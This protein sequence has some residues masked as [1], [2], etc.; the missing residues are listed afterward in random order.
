M[1]K[2]LYIESLHRPFSQQ[3]KTTKWVCEFIASSK[4]K[5]SNSNLNLDFYY[6]LIN[7]L[8]KEYRKE[9]PT[10]F[11]GLPSD[12]AIYNIHDYLKSK[13][14]KNFLEE[15][16]KIIKSR[17]TSLER[18]IY[19]T[20]KAASY[21]V[22]LA[23]DKFGLLNEKNKLTIYGDALIAMKSNFYNLSN[24]EKE[25]F[26]TRI[27]EVDFHLFMTQCLFRKLE[28]KY[29]LKETIAEQLEFIDKYLLIRHFNFTSSSLKNYN[30]VRGYWTDLLNITDAN[31]NIR[32]KYL[33][34]I[35]SEIHFKEFFI[36]LNFLFFNFEKQ[37]FKLKKNYI[38]KSEKFL[39]I[40]NK[41][42]KTNISDLGFVNLYDI[43]KNLH[44]S[45][46]KFQLF[47]NDFYEFEK[48]EYNIFFSNTVNSID[49]RERF[50]LRNRPVIKIK[51][52]KHGNKSFV[53][54]TPTST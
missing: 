33:S 1:D 3:L 50:L 51:I 27:L 9:T 21:Y 10:E 36:E 28:S 53:G 32:K 44:I 48:N 52:K 18:Q 35:N 20:Y 14:K 46:E 25:F 4:I 38:A 37:N 13:G 43:K 41:Y 26:F 47:L 15:V 45:F 16:P 22:N 7:L 19:S 23:K 39:D 17:N 30:T 40:Y 8:E 11:K 12:S 29:S 6:F 34:I 24:C 2:V 31:G 49:R 42:I 5:I 54:K